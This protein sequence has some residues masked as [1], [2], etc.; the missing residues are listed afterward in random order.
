[1]TDRTLKTKVQ[2]LQELQAEINNLTDQAE[3]LKD[4][5]KAEMNA[6]ETDELC[7][8]TAVIRWQSVKSNR[9]DSKSFKTEHADLY[10]KYL[11]EQETRRFTLIPA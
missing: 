2:R 8:G 9:F 4:Q 6:R 5:I 7:A 1:M 11:Q 3:S 10:T